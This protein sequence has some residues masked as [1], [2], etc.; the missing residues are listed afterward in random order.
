MSQLALPLRLLDHAVFESFWRGGNEALVSYL[1]ALVDS[2]DRQGCWLFGG[3]AT[4]KTHL[5]QAVC[6]KSRDLAVYVAIGEF[7]D[8]G[9]GILDGLASRRFV[10]LDDVHL[11]AGDDDWELKLFDLYNQLADQGGSLLATANAPPRECRFRLADLAS[12]FSML[13]AFRVLALD[14]ADRIRA[15]QLR[16]QFRGLDLPQDTATF[17]LNRS[18]RDM[19]SL[20]SLLDQLDTAALE[21]QRR[22]T[23]PFVRETLNSSR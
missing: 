23:I 22:L 14:E 15:L 21:A 16:A 4:G 3:E 19:A 7:A 17:L 11:V 12:R 2:G 5:L 18:R 9:P 1:E 20:Y 10:C 13:P 6:E 8:S